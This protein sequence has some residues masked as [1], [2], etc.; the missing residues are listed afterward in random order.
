MPFSIAFFPVGGA[1]ALLGATN[2][3][4]W[5]VIGGAAAIYAASEVNKA[6]EERKKSK[7]KDS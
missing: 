5:V 4:T 2:P 7:N 3:I 6:V 1:I